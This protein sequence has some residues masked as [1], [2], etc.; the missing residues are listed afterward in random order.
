MA[1]VVS[2]FEFLMWDGGCAFVGSNTGV[3]PVHAHQAI[4]VCFGR[5]GTIRLRP[6]D[7]APWA[8]YDIGLVAS[9]QPHAFDAT[10]VPYGAVLFVEPEQPTFRR[11]DIVVVE[12]D[13]RRIGRSGNLGRCGGGNRFSWCRVVS[14]ATRGHHSHHQHRGTGR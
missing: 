2:D 7:D 12:E 13:D 14:G 11:Y 10:G 1:N 5:T 4:Q 8:S 6:S 3:L 9:Q